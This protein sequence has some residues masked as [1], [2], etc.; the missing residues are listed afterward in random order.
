LT[1]IKEYQLKSGK[2][3]ASLPVKDKLRTGRVAG[4]PS[5]PVNR[6]EHPRGRTGPGEGQG[7]HVKAP[8][9]VPLLVGTKSDHETNVAITACNDYLR[10]GP[11]RSISG[12][13]RYYQATDPLNSPTRN[14]LYHF[15]WDF[16]W[17]ERADQYDIRLDAEKTRFANEVMKTGLAEAHKRVLELKRVAD[18]LM[19]EISRPGRLYIKDF[20]QVGQG[21]NAEVVQVIRFNSPLVEQY[22]GVLEDLAK[23]TGGRQKTGS[24]DDNPINISVRIRPSEQ[25][26]SDVAGDE[27]V[28]QIRPGM[29]IVQIAAATV[30]EGSK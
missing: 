17:A 13:Y 18:M 26:E 6:P 16:N 1:F 20:K 21:K 19:E 3:A 8:S 15:S 27:D 28:G 5:Y 22:R 30:E 7:G 9:S 24:T 23:E 12:L 10:M 2:I 29:P 11:S 4:G 14:S 25:A